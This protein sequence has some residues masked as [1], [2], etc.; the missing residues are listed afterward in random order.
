[1]NYMGIVGITTIPQMEMILRFSRRSCFFNKK[2]SIGYLLSQ[3]HKYNPTNKRYADIRVIDKLLETTR[4]YNIFNV[5][6]YN[7]RE[8]EFSREIF[9]IMR[10]IQNNEL[11]KGLQLN[12][13][14]PDLNE[15]IKIRD[16]YPQLK[17]IYQWRKS[18]NLKPEELKH[19]DYILIDSSG[20]RGLPLDVDYA[21]KVY[22]KTFP[23]VKV[24]FAGGL[25]PDNL[26]EI[27]LRINEK[28]G[29]D[30]SF[31]AESGLRNQFNQ[32][33]LEKVLDFIEAYSKYEVE[34]NGK[35]DRY[36]R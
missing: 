13:N 25:S 28:I 26:L 36:F 20:G 24:G 7:T 11:I 2:L 23:Y 9:W 19:I 35:T 34:T 14:N 33:D 4:T 29:N 18:T 1:M 32:L 8:R 16:K 15:I 31:D 12:I 6:H 27:M 22:K 21:V 3:K 5:I 30:F 17:I 10:R